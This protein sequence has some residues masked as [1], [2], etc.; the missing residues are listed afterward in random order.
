ML[1]VSEDGAT[2]VVFLQILGFQTFLESR[3]SGI[4]II[5]ECLSLDLI[6]NRKPNVCFILIV[7]GIHLQAFTAVINQLNVHSLAL[8]K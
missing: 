5:W 7:S 6:L 8:E 2:D 4:M 3:F 1:W